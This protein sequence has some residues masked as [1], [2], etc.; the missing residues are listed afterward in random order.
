MSLNKTDILAGLQCEKHLFL[1][2]NHPE[3]AKI[4]D[5]P[6]ALTGRVV[7]EHA[8][9][10]F[11]G[12]VLVERH[13][14]DVDPLAQTRQL[15]ED[16]SIQTIFEAG[17]RYQNDQ[18]ALEAFVDVLERTKQGWVL[19]EIKSGTRVQ[20]KHIDDVTIQALILARSGIPITRYNLM[21]INPDF[22]Y[23]GDHDYSQLFLRENITD[24]V[25]AHL[26]DIA[27]RLSDLE[28]LVSAQEPVKQIGS[29][30]KNPFPC[31]FMR[32]C[33]SIGPR[34]PVY[35]LPNGADAA[36]KLIGQGIIDIRDI[37]PD[38][39]TSET[40]QRVRNITIQ[41]K[42]ELLPEARH[43]LTALEFPRY[44]L[45]FECM[46]FAIPIWKD[47]RPYDQ[48][49]FQW[50]CH[51][52]SAD[53]TLMHA[54]FLDTSGDD[55]RYAFAQALLDECGSQGP[56]IVYNQAFEKRIIRELAR[57]FPKLSRSLLA[58]NERMFDLL[59]V[60]RK[61]YYHPDMKGSW[62]IKKVLPCLVP[63][64]R[65]EALGVVQ[66]GTMAQAVYLD[67]IHEGVSEKR[68]DQL[69]LDLLAYCGL[70]TL[71]MVKIVEKLQQIPESV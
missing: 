10:V 62:S 66:D 46:Q 8:R 19:T 54:E 64:L 51:V 16:P 7:Q 20:D 18:E 33:E 13:R 48:L 45:D 37:P 70:D 68:K 3:R 1:R 57:T 15:M 47:T 25:R 29:H 42:A 55:P 58:L 14:R 35:G 30:C 65:Y 71:A 22:R 49:P 4:N 43:I 67:I 63:E 39:L 61:Y 21:H 52:E 36:R 28:L 41:G 59:P 9:R 60:V 12:G 38:F 17:F 5:S 26:A 2:K 32:Y 40:Q 50:S 11:P 69:R 34:Y 56:I 6:A 53:G 27:S 31:P 44:Y 23:Q 24:S